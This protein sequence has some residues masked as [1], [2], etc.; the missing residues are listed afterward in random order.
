MAEHRTKGAIEIPTLPLPA[1]TGANARCEKCHHYGA[2]TRYVD[3]RPMLAEY[4]ASDLGIAPEYLARACRNCD[5]T[6]AEDLPS[7]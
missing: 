3:Q 6:W 4:Q 2:S 1:Y 7:D 5:Y